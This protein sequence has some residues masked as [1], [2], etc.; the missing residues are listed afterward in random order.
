[1]N[2]KTTIQ[3]NKLMQLENAMFMCGVYN[4]ETLEKPIASVHQIYNTISSQ[5]ILFT[6]QQSSVTLR[7]LYANMLGFTALF[8][9]FTTL[10]KN[11]TGQIYCLI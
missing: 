2:S 11:S 3:H 5:E 4:A 1:M 8:N 10:F 9:K 7:S 6:G